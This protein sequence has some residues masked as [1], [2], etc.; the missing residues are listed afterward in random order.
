MSAGWSLLSTHG[1]VLF[2]IA[3]N[4][5][6]THRQIAR[7]LNVT[8]KRVA[9]V[10]RHLAQEDFICVHRAGRRNWYS[11]NRSAQFRSPPLANVCLDDVVRIIESEGRGTIEASE[12]AP[13][14]AS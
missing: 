4:P 1:A 12:V 5:E 14:A 3:G 6:S 9:D 10:I 7:A 13:V 11:L 8:E 2:Y